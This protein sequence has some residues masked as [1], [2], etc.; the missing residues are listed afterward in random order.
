MKRTLIL[1]F[2]ALALVACGD[3]IDPATSGSSVVRISDDDSAAHGLLN[4]AVF[5]AQYGPGWDTLTSPIE[6]VTVEVY[7]IVPY[8]EALMTPPDTAVVFD[9]LPA[10]TTIVIDTLPVD[11]VVV[12]SLPPEPPATTLLLR[13][14]AKTDA[15]GEFTV[16][17]IPAGQYV[18][19]IV[20]EESSFWAP[21]SGW[22]FISDGAATLAGT[23][24]IWPK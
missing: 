24:H 23:F 18:I 1:S 4:G 14:T 12:D 9:T 20:P 7:Q 2:L 11:T 5:G 6:G 8:E 17:G 13:G 21:S 3:D 19:F 22:T 10:D 15:D 16:T